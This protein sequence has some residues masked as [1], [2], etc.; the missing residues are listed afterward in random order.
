MR[1]LSFRLVPHAV[2]CGI[3]AAAA[4]A[5]ANAVPVT[6][7]QFVQQNGA[8]Q[9]WSIVTNAGGTTTVTANSNVFFSFS[10]VLGLPFA[11]AEPA[12]FSLSA[13][14]TQL[15]N[16]GVN[17]GTGDS[18]VQPGYTGTFSFID[19]GVAAG[20]N[21]L[22]GTFATSG[23]PSTSGAQLRST[24]G[25]SSAGFGATTTAIDPNLLVLSSAYLNFAN[26]TQET[27]QFS[28]SSLIPSFS[29]GLVLAGQARPATGTFN[30]SGSG[31]FS[32]NPG[33]TALVPEPA[34]MLLLG[35][36]LAGLGAVR[37]RAKVA[38]TAAA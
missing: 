18:Y 38:A 1:A 33:P 35:A 2:A 29:T 13:T 28:L 10:G 11:G 12:I 23:N 26:Q 30:A 21:L 3:L 17:C 24:I 36:G 8:Q 20:K 15:G 16:C 32:S 25:G 37:R 34:S 6:F 14:S 31:T 22:S 19:A 27:A 5:P 7:A 9:A 4:I